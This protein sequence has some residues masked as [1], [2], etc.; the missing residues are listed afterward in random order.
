MKS[1]AGKCLYVDRSSSI[2]SWALAD[3]GKIVDNGDFSDSSPRS[4]A[5][6]TELLSALRRNGVHPR[7][8]SR[9]VV[10]LGPGSFSGIRAALA[11]VQGLALPCGAEVVG[12][13]SAAALAAGNGGEVVAIRGD[14]RRG[15]HWLGLFRNNGGRT[16]LS[17]GR[18]VTHT[19]ADFSIAT[20]AEID[21]MIPEGASVVSPDDKPVA[22]A[23]A[24]LD[25]ADGIV[26]PQPIYL[27]PAV[28]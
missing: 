3:S 12:M 4:P 9:Y 5:W 17:D 25:C 14:A 15:T 23:L 11:A 19:L 8:I 22:T 24:A 26:N 10:G 7:D 13:S 1:F 20:P 6:F 27:H 18:E 21:A 28:Q 16:T 2:G